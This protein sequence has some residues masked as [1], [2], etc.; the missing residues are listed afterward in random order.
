MRKR[1]YFDE[2]LKILNSNQRDTL[3]VLILAGDSPQGN[4]KN[5]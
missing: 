1:S 5:E 3:R 4:S 2:I